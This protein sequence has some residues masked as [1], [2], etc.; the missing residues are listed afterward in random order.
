[1][2]VSLAAIFGTLVV[3]ATVLLWGTI[4]RNRWGI[5]LG[6]LS[7]PRCNTPSPG[8]RPPQSTR[9]KLWGGWTCSKCGA[10]ID[11]WGRDLQDQDKNQNTGA[12]SGSRPDHPKDHRLVRSP[13]FWL[14]VLV[15]IALD[16]WSPRGII[17]DIP[18][19]LYF[20]YR[21]TR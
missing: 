3:V 17:L 12:A 6:K 11:K 5:R 8:R 7:C 15:L 10:E 9:Q 18:I 19:A 21:R 16:I 14:V 13:L 4:T 2:V 20:W 1:M